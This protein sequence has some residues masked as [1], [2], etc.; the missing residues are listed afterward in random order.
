MATRNRLTD[1]AIANI[2][3][4]NSARLVKVDEGWEVELCNGNMCI[5][6]ADKNGNPA[7]YSAK[8]SVSKALER[9]N[10]EIKI[11]VKSQLCS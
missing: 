2:E 10:P 9:H 3:A 1:L 6:L 4:A 11:K 5:R 7:V 8:S